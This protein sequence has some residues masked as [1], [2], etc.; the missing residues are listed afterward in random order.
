MGVAGGPRLLLEMCIEESKHWQPVLSDII[1]DRHFYSRLICSCP[2]LWN[3][4]PSQ[5]ASHMPTL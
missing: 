4:F 2:F 1:G 5:A 3:K